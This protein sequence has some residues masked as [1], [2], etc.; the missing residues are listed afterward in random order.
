MEELKINSIRNLN[1]R[2][3]E[4][5][6]RWFEDKVGSIYLFFIPCDG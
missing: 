2:H 1:K 3:E 6:V 5:F 4:H